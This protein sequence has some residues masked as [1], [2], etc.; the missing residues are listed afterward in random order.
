MISKLIVFDKEI[1]LPTPVEEAKKN[2]IVSFIK[3]AY[4]EIYSRLERIKSYEILVE[5][6][7]AIVVRKDAILG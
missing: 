4:P 5:G 3:E 2:E 1:I 6:D 7:T